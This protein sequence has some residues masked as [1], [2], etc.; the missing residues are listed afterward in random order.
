MN[1]LSVKPLHAGVFKYHHPQWRFSRLA[2]QRYKTKGRYRSISGT[3][4]SSYS[5]ALR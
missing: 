4:R 2:P 1:S 3:K 5:Q